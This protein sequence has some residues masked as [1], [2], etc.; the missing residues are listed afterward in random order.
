MSTK[1][2]LIVSGIITA[3]T[4]ALESVIPLFD[5]SKE[6]AILAAINAVGSA[7]IAVVAIFKDNTKK[8]AS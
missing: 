4:T 6:S 1:T 7:S 2:F 8:I 3:V 5:L